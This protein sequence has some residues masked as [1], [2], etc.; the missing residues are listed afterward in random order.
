MNFMR[1]FTVF[2]ALLLLFSAIVIIGT[3]T[4]L[5]ASNYLNKSIDSQDIYNSDHLHSI[6]ENR[7]SRLEVKKFLKEQQLGMLVKL[8]HLY[9]ARNKM[10]RLVEADNIKKP[11]EP[12][13]DRVTYRELLKEQVELK[14]EIIG[15]YYLMEKQIYEWESLTL[16]N[17]HVRYRAEQDMH[18]FT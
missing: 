4:K 15:L 3:P 5:H 13:I 8:D 12:I 10:N 1:L 6:N 17:E 16:I 18:F 11:P 14:Q 9:Q 7:L 2:S